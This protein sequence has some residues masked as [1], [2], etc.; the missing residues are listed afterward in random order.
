MC[1]LLNKETH[2]LLSIKFI[3]YKYEVSMRLKAFHFIVYQ[4][5]F[6]GKYDRVVGS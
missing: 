6:P 5:M 3:G 4:N 2:Q 1:L